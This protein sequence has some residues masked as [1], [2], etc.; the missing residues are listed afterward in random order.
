MLMT[1]LG[2]DNIFCFGEK[3]MLFKPQDELNS[4]I[5]FKAF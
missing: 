4:A 5:L 1:G 2:K 3:K